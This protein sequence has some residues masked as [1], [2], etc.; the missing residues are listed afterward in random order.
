MGTT[1]QA[2]LRATIENY[3][4]RLWPICRSITGNGVR[5]SIGILSE[6]IPFTVHEVSSGTAVFDWIIPKEWNIHDAYIITPTGERICEF[7]K[8]NLHVVNYAVPVN[9]EMTLEELKPHLHSV[10]RLPDAVPYVTSYYKERWGFC[11][12]KNDLEKLPEGKY[13]VV[14]DS[15]LKNGHLTYADH[16]LKGK[17]EK[18]IVFSSYICHPSMAN[19]ELSGPLV[20]AFLY[21]L[22]GTMPGRKYSYRFILAP[23]TIGAITYLSRNGGLMKKN[24]LAGFVINCVGTNASPVYKKSRNGNSIG[25]EAAINVLKNSGMKFRVDEFEPVG[26]DERQYCSPAFD[27]PFGSLMRSKYSEYPEYHTSADNKDFISFDAM[28][29]TVQLYLRIA[30]TIE[31]EEILYNTVGAGE[32]NLGKRNL[33][34]DLAGAL[35]VPETLLLRMRLLNFMDGTKTLSGFI[36]KYNYPE[37]LVFAEA[38]ILKANSLLKP[39]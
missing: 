24:T 25:D 22:I 29:E 20:L 35:S 32:P 30:E 14:I 2:E 26:S 27:L 37:Q 19:N 13:K 28:L 5:E 15:E 3:F 17:S 8:N 38:E 31:K 12:S 10:E 36:A 39:V 33:Y 7:R 21:K 9:A 18:E 4:D 6:I 16:L 11:I 1:P 34:P 23:E